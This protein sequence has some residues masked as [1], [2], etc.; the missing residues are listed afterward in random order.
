MIIRGFLEAIVETGTEKVIWSFHDPGLPSHE[1]CHLLENG[2]E[3]RVLDDAGGTLWEGV[4]RFERLAASP[5]SRLDGSPCGE[6]ALGVCFHGTQEGVDPET[7]R[8][9]FAERR[10]AVL[11]RCSANSRDREPHPFSGPV[12]GL[13]ARLAALPPG[14]AEALFE[15]ALCR[16]L[17]SGAKAEWRGLAYAWGLGP[18]EAVSLLNYPLTGSDEVSLIIPERG[19]ETLLPFFFPV[20]E[21]LGLLFRLNAALLWGLPDARS[22]ASWLTSANA[23]LFG[24]RPLHLLHGGE[25]EGVRPA[26]DAARADLGMEE[27]E[28]AP[29]TEE[30]RHFAVVEELDAA[31]RHNAARVLSYVERLAGILPALAREVFGSRDAATEWLM[32]PTIAL[33]QKRPIDLLGSAAGRDRIERLLRRRQSGAAAMY[34]RAA[35]RRAGE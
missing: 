16:W 9:L 12:D 22:R 4:V 15:G 6:G 27:A 23:R 13:R 33:A 35:V 11:R 32:R 17:G 10:R 28:G 21:R 18:A 5:T 3:L 7:W 30:R 1:G 14:R 25:M 2:D 31:R 26:L 20:F 29:S 34:D 24:L 19:G 8:H